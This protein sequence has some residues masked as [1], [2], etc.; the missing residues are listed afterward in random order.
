MTKLKL[1]IVITG[2]LIGL[3]AGDTVGA[4]PEREENTAAPTRSWSLPR[5]GNALQGRVPWPGS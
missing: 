5:G 3:P 2:V 4:A 1:G